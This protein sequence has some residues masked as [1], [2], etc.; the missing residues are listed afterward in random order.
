MTEKI[1]NNERSDNLVKYG[2][3]RNPFRLKML[4]FESIYRSH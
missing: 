1:A 2:I 4:N 3:Q